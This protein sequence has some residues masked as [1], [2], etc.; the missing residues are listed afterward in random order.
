MAATRRSRWAQFTCMALAAAAWMA[1]VALEGL[2]E[3]LI[4]LGIVIVLSAGIWTYAIRQR[5]RTFEGA[6]YL[7]KGPIVFRRKN[8]LSLQ[9]PNVRLKRAY[10][11]RLVGFDLCSGYLEVS[12]TGLHWS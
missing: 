5:N 4:V 9:F 6:P 2:S 10:L 1:R 11:R 8:L 7:W 3:L 12:M